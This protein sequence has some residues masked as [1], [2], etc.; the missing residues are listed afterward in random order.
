MKKILF[1]PLVA[2]L[3]L[4]SSCSFF[5]EDPIEKE[6]KLMNEMLQGNKC[7]FYK[8]IKVT[9][10]SVSTV[11]DTTNTEAGLKAEHTHKLVMSLMERVLKTDS[12]GQH[13]MKPQDYLAA[14]AEL[15]SLKKTIE[16]ANEDDYPTLFE[17]VLHLSGFPKLSS[18]PVDFGW[19][20]TTYEHLVL[21]AVWMG[22]PAAPKEFQVYEIAAVDASKINAP[23]MKIIA[24]LAKGLTFFEQGWYYMSEEECDHYLGDLEE[25]EK[26]IGN[27]LATPVF[28]EAKYNTTASRYHQLHACG[29]LLRGLDKKQ[30]EREDEALEDFEGFLSDMDKAGVANESVWLIGTYVSLK[31]E[32]H[33]KAIEYLTKLEQSP[34]YGEDEKKTIAEIKGYVAK[35]DKESAMNMISDKVFMVKVAYHY[36]KK[37]VEKTKGFQ[38]LQSDAAGQKFLQ[39]PAGMNSAHS[40]MSGFSGTD[41]LGS[42]AK[43]VVKGLF[44]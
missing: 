41:S 8:G 13:D 37:A 26:S 32:E 7:I 5:R 40:E 43:R 3:L 1:L 31:K 20:N 35:R 11:N 38:Q 36:G 9:L 21:S 22:V 14:A 27:L 4:A 17:N 16:S 30:S 2:G 15:Y 12:T 18:G 23:D 10:R 28:P 29:L 42:K 19:Y 25:N 39:L 34:L 44:E 24:E 6:R 33:D